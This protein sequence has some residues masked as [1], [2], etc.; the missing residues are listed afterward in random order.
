MIFFAK[1]SCIADNLVVSAGL[2]ILLINS[3]IIVKTGNYKTD[4]IVCILCYILMYSIHEKEISVSGDYMTNDFN[5]LLNNAVLTSPIAIEQ[6]KMKY[7][8]HFSYQLDNC[9][10]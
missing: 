10:L 8:M 1:I 2:S 9:R 4:L 3:E 6:F 7:V 5:Y